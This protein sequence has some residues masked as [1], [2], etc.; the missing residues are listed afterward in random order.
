MLKQKAMKKD[1]IMEIRFS[2][3]IF[4]SI[5]AIIAL[6]SCF[7]AGFKS[8]CP[9][10]KETAYKYFNKT[11]LMDLKFVSTIG[12]SPKD[13]S[14]VNSIDGVT[15]IM[16][17]YSKDMFLQIDDENIVIKTMSYNKNLTENDVYYI[18]RPVLIDGRMPEK[19]GECVVE[20]KINSPKSFVLG[21]SITLS[22]PNESEPLSNYLKT[23]TYKIVGIVSTP[24]YIGYKRGPTN[25]GNGEV[26]S[27]I[28]IPEEDFSMPYYT[29]LY[30]T[31][32]GLSDLE[33]FSKEYQDK[34]D[35]YIPKIE[36]ALNKSINV[37]FE[38]LMSKAN[39]KIAK[40]KRE[41]DGAEYLANADLPT[42]LADIKNGEKEIDNLNK[43][44]AV[45]ENNNSPLQTIYR[46]SIVQ[47]ESKIQLAKDKI[48]MI[49][50]GNLPSDEEINAKIQSYKDE[51]ASA[52]SEIS[53]I[54]EPVVYTFSRHS[55]EDYASFSSDSEKINAIS[56]IFPLFFILVAALVSLTTMTRMVEENRTQIGI[57]KALGYG[58]FSIAGKFFFYGVS[59][60][61]IGTF[62]GLYA[63]FKL[64]PKL[65]YNSY[66]MMYNI[67][68]FTTPFRWNFALITIA[69][70]LLCICFAVFFACFT[71]LKSNPAQI[72]RPKSPATGKRVILEN[73]PFI[74]IKLGFLTKVTIRNLFRFKKR[75]LMTI[76][77]IAGCTSLMVTGFGLSNSISSI[78]F[79]QFDKV[80]LFDGIAAVNS[81][82]SLDEA[83]ELLHNEYISKSMS[84]YQTTIDIVAEK[85]TKNVNL[86]IPDEISNFADYIS[87]QE[88]VS[89]VKLSLTDDGIIVSEKLAMLLSLKVGDNV[90]LQSMEN[91]P[92]EVKITGINE[93]YTLHYI[94]MSPDLYSSLYGKEPENNSIAFIMENPN[95]ANE[96]LLATSL[97]E[98]KQILGVQFSSQAGENF[99]AITK[100]LNS[101]VFII[102]ICAGALAFIVLYN[103]S[104]INVSERARELATIKLLGFYDKEVSS[105]ISHE[106]TLSSFIG[107]I[108]GL[109]AGT[110]LH[111][112]VVK[113]AEIDL[114]M[115]NRQLNIQSF[116]FAGILTM[117]FTFI[118]NF[119]L[120]FTLKK[121]NMVE[122][123]KSID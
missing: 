110:F 104:N 43:K 97:L 77:G 112:F 45:A 84:C 96:K 74:W 120:H 73:A 71:V 69:A 35:E 20:V 37:R 12:I 93:N 106:N 113:T 61:L 82:E 87:L 18:N 118:V 65:I 116:I 42:L 46:A 1:T 21:N 83:K 58:K 2:L 56:K 64:F 70:A 62:I 54:K 78:A 6:G 81:N 36:D 115:F 66:Q 55:S 107:M 50:N 14:A 33:P 13:V 9:D 3:S 90:T 57:Y 117:F 94:Y 52:E 91:K 85:D 119:V 121:I 63:G 10:M 15:G 44:L 102:I 109:F 47:G 122:S 89:R 100:N 101:I 103:L 34:L 23:D 72:M 7:F 27:F 75:F 98:N 24:I 39:A 60:T 123:L 28:M 59:A 80:F 53:Q 30:A 40:A 19:S 25:V 114:V 41:L 22:S 111:R 49:Q 48:E 68:D 105:Y 31:I 32:E 76:I 99:N 67:P 5:L 51:I 108:I 79:K 11:N 8:T 16:P 29:E 88:R 38:D 86:L 4:L 92:R 95:S 17:S 26:S